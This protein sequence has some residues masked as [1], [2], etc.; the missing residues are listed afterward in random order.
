MNE[1]NKTVFQDNESC[2]LFAY[3]RSGVCQTDLQPSLHLAYS[4]DA[5]MWTPLNDNKPVWESALPAKKI[6]DPYLAK[7][8]DGVWR[9]VFTCGEKQSFGMS[10]SHDLIHFSEAKAVPVMAAYEHCQNT[11]A[12]EFFYDH[13]KDEYVV[14][15]SSSLE[16]NTSNCIFYAITKDFITYTDT[17]VLFK[18]EYPVIDSHIVFH[19]GIYYLFYKDEYSAFFKDKGTPMATRIVTSQSATGPYT[20][21]SGYI[22]PD[23]TEGA[24]IIKPDGSDVWL[25]YTDVWNAGRWVLSESKDL[26]H[27][28]IVHESKYAIPYQARHGSFTRISPA[29]LNRLMAHYG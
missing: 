15:W 29:E 18:P 25:L 21:E 22:T 13:Q 24:E 7:C 1:P 6:R 11:W 8:K 27:W 10:E 28:D 3:F 5:Y 17:K 19:E 4:N 26:L 20:N 16:N 9:V 12:P 14:H 23:I 2:Y